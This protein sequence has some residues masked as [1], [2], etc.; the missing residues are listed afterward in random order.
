ME[1]RFLPTPFSGLL[2]LPGETVA[3]S[4]PRSAPAPPR[5]SCFALLGSRLLAACRFTPATLLMPS[6]PAQLGLAFLLCFVPRP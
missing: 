2:L 6:W 5:P 1:Q 4:L 3:S